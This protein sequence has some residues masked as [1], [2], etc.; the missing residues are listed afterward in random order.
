V[1][2]SKVYLWETANLERGAA[3]IGP[4]TY[5]AYLDLI[6]ECAPERR[7]SRGL[8]LVFTGKVIGDTGEWP[9]AINLWEVDGWDGMVR[10][11]NAEYMGT[12]AVLGTDDTVRPWWIKAARVRT[13]GCDRLL[14]PAPYSPT[15]QDIV[16]QK[17]VGRILCHEIVH[18]APLQ[19][20]AYHERLQRHWLPI[21]ERL[22]VR[23]FG[24]FKTATRNDSEVINIWTLDSFE[25]WGRF[26]RAQQSDAEVRAWRDV[27]RDLGADW[28]RC[29]IFPHPATSPISAAIV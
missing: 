28:E 27:L 23:L 1:A 2:N 24:S 21:A 14:V 13:R 10:V 17:I 22:G 12:S 15:L 16:D 4:D 9:V 26:E 18:V 29:L 19:A 7:Q 5:Q 25:T 11:L 6:V 8:T 3:E 20:D